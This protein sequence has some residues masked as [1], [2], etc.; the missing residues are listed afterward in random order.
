MDGAS[1]RLSGL[2][3]RE[4]PGGLRLEE[5]PAGPQ[6][7]QSL[8]CPEQNARQ[9]RH[10]LLRQGDVLQAASRR[11][12]S[13][14]IKPLHQRHPLEG[15]TRRATVKTSPT[16]PVAASTGTFAPIWHPGMRY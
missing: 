8:N 6:P 7:L 4:L 10:Q 13:A 3:A 12:P 11:S 9:F 1:A 14:E 2:P 5:V 15:N 16:S